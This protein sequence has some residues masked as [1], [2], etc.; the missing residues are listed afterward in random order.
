MSTK[1]MKKTRKTRY[2]TSE[3]LMQMVRDGLLTVTGSDSGEYIRYTTT[4]DGVIHS[5]GLDWSQPGEEVLVV[6][7]PNVISDCHYRFLLTA[8]IVEEYE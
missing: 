6:E 4:G 3:Q 5:V 2:K 8:G 7:H 1:G